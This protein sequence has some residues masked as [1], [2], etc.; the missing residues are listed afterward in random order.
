M[1]SKIAYM[2]I[3]N[4]LLF[5]YNTYSEKHNLKILSIFGYIVLIIDLIQSFLF[6]PLYLSYLEVK[7]YIILIIKYIKISNK[8][9]FYL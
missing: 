3:G 1:K 7:I 4:K 2:N 9:N 8:L 6:V 5:D